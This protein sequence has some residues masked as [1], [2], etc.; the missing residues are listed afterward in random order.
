MHARCRSEKGKWEEI[1]YMLISRHGDIFIIDCSIFRNDDLDLH[2]LIIVL[3]S[4]FR[5]E[6]RRS[7]GTRKMYVMQFYAEFILLYKRMKVGKE[8]GCGRT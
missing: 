8:K 1:I 4:T 6:F 5:S 2:V 3:T 7:R